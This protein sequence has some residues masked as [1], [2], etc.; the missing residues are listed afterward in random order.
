MPSVVRTIRRVSRR[1]I[2]PTKLKRTWL[3][4]TNI[5]I[6]LPNNRRVFTV[7]KDW[8]PPLT[9]HISSAPTLPE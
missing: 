6:H 3:G 5:L 7:L 1:S 9:Y 8:L 2:V 4:I